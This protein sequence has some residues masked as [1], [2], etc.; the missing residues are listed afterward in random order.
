MSTQRKPNIIFIMTDQQRW[1][2]MGRFNPQ[3]KTPSIDKLAA[4]GIIFDQGVCQCPM[5]NAGGIFDENHLPATP[6]PQL[7]KDSGYFTAGFGK[8]HWNNGFFTNK[9][10]KRGFDI[11]AEGQSSKS[12]CYE[13]GAVMMDDEGQDPEGLKAYGEETHGWGGGEEGG[14]GS[15]L[16]NWPLGQF[17][18]LIRGGRV[19]YNT[20]ETAKMRRSN[21]PMME[22]FRSDL[23]ER[24]LPR[25]QPP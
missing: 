5:C 25:R 3:I 16:W 7:L 15:I 13:Y 24:S 23:E 22:K 21:P 18:L 11:R 8:T 9:P 20:L 6:L 19:R 14:L 1:D 17:L 4:D 2:C 10:S 12:S